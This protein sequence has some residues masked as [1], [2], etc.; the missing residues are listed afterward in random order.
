M[1]FIAANRFWLLL[2]VAA[3]GA[4]YV[5]MQLRRKRYAVRFTNL[6]LLDSVAPKRPGWRRHVPAA[7]LLVGLVSLVTA[8]ARPTRPTKV[9]RERATIVMAVDVSISMEATDVEPNRLAAA[10][11]A[12]RIFIN[13]LPPR[14]N[15]GLVSFSGNAQVLVPPTTDHELV[16]TAV[17]RL[18]LG[19]RTAIGEAIFASLDSIAGVPGGKK[20]EKTPARIVLMS[21]GTTT[22]GRPNELAA[23]AAKKADVP[24]WTI[25]YGTDDG[26]VTVE[27]RT[28]PV[29]VNKDALRD[30]AR[31]TGGKFFEA[32][33]ASEIKK[34]YSDIGSAVGYITQRRE[35]GTW[36]V[37][38]GIILTLAAAAGSLLW[39]SRLP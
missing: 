3:L 37:G 38:I 34:V 6:A 13:E 23:D 31:T 17:T 18:Q 4:A 26:T 30:V 27:G 10:K 29:P 22:S 9:P 8:V 2:L 5:V 24:I 1:R 21:D 39:G 7:L 33:S 35:V 36:F 11:A 20:G 12:A 19:P 14:V 25:A 32:G 16:K 15:V 28:V